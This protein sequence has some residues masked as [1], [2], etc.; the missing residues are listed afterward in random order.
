MVESM[1]TEA[2]T[3]TSN[4]PPE[5]AFGLAENLAAALSYIAIFGLVLLFVEEDN[6]F[7]RFHAAQAVV[8]AVILFGVSFG[9]TVTTTVLAT[10]P[11]IGSFATLIP[12]VI[13]LGGLAVWLVLVYKAYSG[14]RFAVPV[15][16]GMAKQLEAAV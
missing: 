3:Q 8:V 16:A 12:M 11:V 6:E 14:E 13:S 10:I 9:L 2:N 5:V 7:V 15:A 1:A 4:R